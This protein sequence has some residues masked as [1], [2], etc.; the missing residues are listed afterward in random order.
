MFQVEIGVSH[1]GRLTD[2]M[3]AMRTWLDHQRF[4]AATFRYTLAPP[5]LL[6]QVDFMAE[7]EAFAFASA[8]CGRVSSGRPAVGHG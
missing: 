2:E 3:S 4:E 7:A 6:F 8:F 1:E 5:G